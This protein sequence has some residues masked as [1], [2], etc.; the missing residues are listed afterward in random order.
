MVKSL[1]GFERFKERRFFES[2]SIKNRITVEA[3]IL[4][5]IS[6]YKNLD[7]IDPNRY[8]FLK[9][10]LEGD[11][12]VFSGIH[13]IIVTEDDEYGIVECPYS[14]DE[15]R[16]IYGSDDNIKGKLILFDTLER[17]SMSFSAAKN[18]RF[19]G[20]Y[21]ENVIDLDKML[22]VSIAGIF[23][24][25]VDGGIKVRKFKGE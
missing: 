2:E 15:L 12:N 23:S 7:K 24:K 16:S 13:F 4:E 8:F 3:C 19:K 1:Y 21:A 17:N 25:H 11:V 14:E 22:P 18:L 5:V 20:S 10:L 9:K 6:P